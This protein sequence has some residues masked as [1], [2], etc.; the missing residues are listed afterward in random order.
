[1]SHEQLTDLIPQGYVYGFVLE[2]ECLGKDELSLCTF[3]PNWYGHFKP[4][5]EHFKSGIS[6][7]IKDKEVDEP[8]IDFSL[9]DEYVELNSFPVAVNDSGSRLSHEKNL[10]QK[11]LDKF[12]HALNTKSPNPEL[13]KRLL[14]RGIGAKVKRSEC[15]LEVVEVFPGS[16]AEISGVRAGDIIDHVWTEEGYRDVKSMQSSEI[17]DFFRQ[18]SAKVQF[19]TIREGCRAEVVCHQ[20]NNHS[21]FCKNYSEHGGS[22][23]VTLASQI[24]KNPEAAHR[25]MEFAIG[26]VGTKRVSFAEKL[27]QNQELGR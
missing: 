10:A 5:F 12:K 16:S 26:K 2:R 4:K 17:V 23:H 18:E 13:Q 14:Y 20:S 15:G 8:K 3:D 21:I 19:S 24:K 7:N 9:I 11:S 6:L 22:S 25:I 1:M 27:A